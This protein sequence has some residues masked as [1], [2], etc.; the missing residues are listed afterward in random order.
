MKLRDQHDD[1]AWQE[2][3]SLYRGYIAAVLRNAGVPDHSNED[4]IQD[5]LLKTWKSLPDFQYDKSRGRFRYWLNTV[6]VNTVRS[7]F[8]KEKRLR[9]ALDPEEQVLLDR[10]VGQASQSELE[11]ISERQWKIHV[12]KLAWERV[13]PQLSN[14]VK[15]VYQAITDGEPTDSIAHRMEIQR[16]TVNVYKMRVEQRWAREVAMLSQLMQ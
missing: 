1:K 7:W 12:A 3:E 9:E 10:F 5:V 16:N 8:R 13:S 2:F 15:T 6:T 4:L 11:E 14:K